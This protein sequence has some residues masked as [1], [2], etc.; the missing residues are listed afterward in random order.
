M[1]HVVRSVS[2]TG[3]KVFYFTLLSLILAMGTLSLQ[4]QYAPSPE[5][6]SWGATVEDPPIE[7][8]APSIFHRPAENSSVAQCER[9][10]KFEANGRR[11][12]ATKAANALVHKWHNAAEAPQAQMTIAR[13]QEERGNHAEAFDEYQ[14]LIDNF[15]GLF[16]FDDVL[17]RQYQIANHLLRPP[18]KFLG[19]SLSSMEDV[20]IRFER[21]VR[22]APNWELSPDA[23]LKAASCHELE[24]DKFEAADALSRLQTRYPTTSAALKASAEEI[25]LRRELAEKFPMDAALTRRAIAAIDNALRTYGSKINRDELASWRRELY[26]AGMNR[27][28]ERANFYDNKQRKPRSALIAYKEFLRTYPDAPQADAVRTRVAELEA[29][30]TPNTQN[31]D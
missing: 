9:V 4:A 17:I 13:L 12:K 30:L 25:R 5:S 21:I 23:L 27:D 28:Y 18:K 22:N 6:Q 15:A 1:Y 31:I 10:Q 3:N 19:L 24:G 29:A 14:Y 7:R 11:K 26:E 8:K 16:P 2:R 20:R